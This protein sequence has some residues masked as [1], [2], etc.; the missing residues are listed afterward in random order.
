LNKCPYCH[1]EG[2]NIIDKAK[3]EYSTEQLKSFID[4]FVNNNFKKF[5][6]LGGEPFLRKDFPIILKYIS[7]FDLNLDIS[8]I[9]SCVF[10]TRAYYEAMHSGLRRINVSMHGFSYDAFKLRN[11]SYKMYQ[12][13]NNNL[14][15]ILKNSTTKVKLNY[16]YSGI[17]DEKDLS[18]FLEWAG[19]RKLLV[20]VLDNLNMDF[21][22][23]DVFKVVTR[24]YDKTYDLIENIDENCLPTLLVRF[25]D[26][27]NVEIK[28]K[29][30][31][32]Y[33]FFKSCETC[34]FKKT[35][36]EGI[37]AMRLDNN[38]NLQPCLIRDDNKFPLNN[39]ICQDGIVE[40]QIKY[41][42]YIRKI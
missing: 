20:S 34:K 37:F 36:K 21:S 42:E 7:N 11:P 1:K 26:G 33:S 40:A 2:S 31:S 25:S 4:F 38:G 12:L 9:T 28:N 13:R 15:M 19:R 41:N 8:A 35:C 27:L 10:P 22:W 24:I 30:V 39:Y 14:E 3:D 5:K 16:V 17:N 6:F 18:Q 23:L 32:E 29:R